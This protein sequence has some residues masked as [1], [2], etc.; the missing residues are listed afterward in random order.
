MA[1]TKELASLLDELMGR[2]RNALPTEAPK[3]L[4]WSD[5]EVCKYFLVDYCPHELFTNTKADLGHCNKMHDE[6]MREAYKKS[7]RYGKCG[8]EHDFYSFLRK[9]HNEMARKISRNRQRL[10]L[11][12]PGGVLTLLVLQIANLSREKL[13]EKIQVLSEKVTALQ[14]QAENLGVEGNVEEAQKIIAMADELAEERDHCQKSFETPP[15]ELKVMEV[16]G[17][18]GCFLIVGDSQHRLDEHLV[19]KQHLGF[20][21]IKE[22]LEAYEKEKEERRTK[23]EDRRSPSSSRDYDRGNR[24]TRGDRYSDRRRSDRSRRSRS[25][26]RSRSRRERNRSRSNDRSRSRDHARRRSSRSRDRASSTHSRDRRR[27]DSSSNNE[28]KRTRVSV[29]DGVER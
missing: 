1:A 20:A 11:T 19:G 23:Y 28:S 7:S 2:S 25:R 27:Y 13:E 24:M 18:C 12:Q 16:C 29:N 22:T 14:A 15:G 5:P 6:R 8:Y 10:E 4:R 3:E 26:S 21:K 9:L 17:I